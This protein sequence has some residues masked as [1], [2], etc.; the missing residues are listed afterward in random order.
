MNRE[1]KFRAWDK[2][3]QKMILPDEY[4]DCYE[5]KVLLGLGGKVY[6][7]FYDSGYYMHDM[8]WEIMQF[9]GLKDKNGKE[10][11][12][13][14]I[15]KFLYNCSNNDRDPFR[16]SFIITGYIRFV[17][18]IFCIYGN[19]G[20]EVD[21]YEIEGN[22]LNKYIWTNL[23]TINDAEV[24]GN[25]YENREFLSDKKATIKEILTV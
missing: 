25:I 18:G 10:I 19:N 8:D 1:I 3:N 17:N 14:D 24:I 21:S 13:G 5:N 20:D 23:Y 16:H 4:D 2:E 9:T 22:I 15:V 7:M 12:E 11:Y 6:Q